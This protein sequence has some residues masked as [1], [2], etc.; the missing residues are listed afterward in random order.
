[1][2]SKTTWERIRVEARTDPWG[3]KS[4]Q[5]VPYPTWWPQATTFKESSRIEISYGFPYL[6][7]WELERG[8]LFNKMPKINLEQM[9]TP[10]KLIFDTMQ[11]VAEL[12]RQWQTSSQVLPT[13]RDKKEEWLQWVQPMCNFWDSNAN[14]SPGRVW[15][16][17]LV[18]NCRLQLQFFGVSLP[19]YDHKIFT[20]DS[21][22]FKKPLNFIPGKWEIM[23]VYSIMVSIVHLI[24]KNPFT[25]F[26]A[27][28]D[29]SFN[30][31]DSYLVE[32]PSSFQFPILQ[33]LKAKNIQ[34]VKMVLGR[35][36]GKNE[37]IWNGT[38]I[39]VPIPGALS[40]M[41]AFSFFVKFY[42]S[43]GFSNLN[44]QDI[45]GIFKGPLFRRLYSYM[46]FLSNLK[47]P[48]Q[49]LLNFSTINR[50]NDILR[51]PYANM[52]S[53]N[54]F[55]MWSFMVMYVDAFH[56]NIDITVNVRKILNETQINGEEYNAVFADRLT[57]IQP[58]NNTIP[59][60]QPQQVVPPPPPPPVIPG[61]ISLGVAVPE[62]VR[63]AAQKERNMIREFGLP[64]DYQKFTKIP[65]LRLDRWLS[66][67]RV[68]W[69]KTA[70]W[71]F[72][73][74]GDQRWEPEIFKYN[75]DFE[76]KSKEEKII[77]FIRKNFPRRLR[78]PRFNFLELTRMDSGWEEAYKYQFELYL[79]WVVLN[80][81]VEDVEKYI[82]PGS[83]FVNEDGSPKEVVDGEEKVLLKNSFPD[84]MMEQEQP[85]AGQAFRVGFSIAFV[86]VNA[87]LEAG[88]GSDWKDFLSN[89]GQ[90]IWKAVKEALIALAEA[91]LA[92]A[93][94]IANAVNKAL[95]DLK[96]YL[97]AGAI[98]VVVVLGGWT[99]ADEEI[100]KLA[101]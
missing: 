83:T 67:F 78:I 89:F 40:Y 63:E 60:Y 46:I 50:P 92:A 4:E 45:H 88:F 54:D 21:N 18:E 24:Q 98:G 29:F 5:G 86:F 19:G 26:L 37:N 65:N 41:T 58:P 96:Y 79:E 27:W 28:K 44:E 62:P 72:L 3:T 94:A 39:D 80:V 66:D 35:I 11:Q 87:A 12:G 23:V 32:E 56:T 1:M 52:R 2:T 36:R 74:I 93:A 31:Y 81:N 48:L 76:K 20:Q 85:L 53:V 75:L 15:I 14:N 34:Q 51:N 70:I 43:N 6:S 82:L 59:N 84:I 30:N 61:G 25:P 8:V 47:N 99:F 17:Y 100:R 91:A 13:G 55:M 16:P 95:P 7:W 73:G 64:V 33:W 22:F 69:R 101:R 57:E 90:K 49:P 38:K 71:N 97:I 9:T 68:T 10:T 77:L 42:E